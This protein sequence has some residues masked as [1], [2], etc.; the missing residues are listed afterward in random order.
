MFKQSRINNDH[1]PYALPIDHFRRPFNGRNHKCS[2]LISEPCWIKT[3][4]KAKRTSRLRSTNVKE[5]KLLRSRCFRI[6]R[7]TA[8]SPFK[9]AFA[10][11]SNVR[12]SLCGR[13]TYNTYLPSVTVRLCTAPHL[14]QQKA[15]D[16]TRGRVECT[17]TTLPRIATKRPA[18]AFVCF[19]GSYPRLVK[20][21]D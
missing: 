12:S 14:T 20:R 9:Q 16:V 5:K 18:E 15:N 2:H 7:R 17:R 19:E 1:P 6:L 4:W 3:K 10:S 11:Y 21:C 8:R 13:H